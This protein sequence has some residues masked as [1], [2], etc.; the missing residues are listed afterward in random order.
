MSIV[1]ERIGRACFALM[2]LLLVGGIGWVILSLP[3]E[4]NGLSADVAAKLDESGV[5]N[6]VTAVLLN[7]RGYDT[8]LEIGVLLVAALGVRALAAD[9]SQTEG[10]LFTPPGPVLTGLLRLIAPLIVVV[11]GYLLWVGGHAPGGAF[12]AG[13]V[14]A[15]LGVLLLLGN[16]QML[17]RVP[18]WLERVVLSVGLLV[19]IGV[20][21][22]V[23]AIDASL[24]QYPPRL[25]KWLIL[26]IEAVC[27][28]SIAAVLTVLFAGGKVASSR[29]DGRSMPLEKEQ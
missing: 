28:L 11:A 21:L 23:M 2:V 1:V 13:A 14:L 10:S 26:A 8:L 22:L 9:R 6:P 24:L 3:T 29:N 12:Q 15:S 5:R 25:A 16:P 20:G 17:P 7:F 4:W 18:D 19:F 27:T